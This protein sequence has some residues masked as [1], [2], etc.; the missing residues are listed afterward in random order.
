MILKG[1]LIHGSGER[2][3]QA[4][5]EVRGNRILRVEINPVAK[6]A[7][8]LDVGQST[9]MPGLIDAHVH[10]WGTRTMD[11]FHRLVVPEEMNLLRAAQDL[12]KL[13]DGGYTS[14]RDAGSRA[15]IFLRN[16][17]NEG[18][19]RGPRIKTP[20]LIINQTGGHL[21]KHF[22][23][24]EEAKGKKTVCRIADGPDE[25]RQAVREQFREGADYIKICVT[26]GLTGE[27]ETPEEMQFTE[28]EIKAIV[29][30]A[31]R[32]NAKV[33]AHAQGL[34]GTKKAVALG[35]QWIEH[36][37]F[38][39]EELCEEMVKRAVIL[40]PTLAISHKFAMEGER[41]GAP[42][43]A[44]EKAKRVLD[45][46][47]KSFE[48]GRRFGVKMAAGTD[49]S[50]APMLPHGRNAFELELMVR[51][52]Y[53]PIEALLAA[54]KIGSEALE[55]EKEVGSIEAGKLAD[56]IVVDGDPLQDVRVLQDSS[57]ISFV[58]KGGEIVKSTLSNLIHTTRENDPAP[59]HIT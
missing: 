20:R 36:G 42:T 33:S 2:A 12:N 28:E 19:L 3:D 51:A 18:T 8:D 57:R 58:M 26:G 24:L 17:V 53:S 55:M 44:V 16:A 38:L 4:I 31:Q 56:L 15:G 39:D 10:L 23:P 59:S 30:E 48:L 13:L 47:V 7:V 46:H 52:G 9:I 49:F 21:D 25:C 27:K 37:V 6:E 40:T 45:I 29:E 54:T 41:Y 43:W 22:I 35:V 14:I 50:G 11:Y 32:K 1:R 5:V 34:N